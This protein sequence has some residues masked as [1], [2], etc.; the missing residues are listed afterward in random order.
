MDPEFSD[1]LTGLM[2]FVRHG[3]TGVD[4]PGRVVAVVDGNSVELRCDRCGAVAGVVQVG[5]M[6]AL[7]GLDCAEAP[8]PYCGK[9]NVF[10]GCDEP[11]SYVC[12]HC[13][14]SAGT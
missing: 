5:I 14:R 1:E 13:G 9:L 7:L 11:P 12:T 8:C 6:E 10:P 4:C 3:I 2:P